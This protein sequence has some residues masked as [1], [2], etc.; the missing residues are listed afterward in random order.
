MHHEQPICMPVACTASQRRVGSSFF[1]P[2]WTAVSRLP[3]ATSTP[4]WCD[5]AAVGSTIWPKRCLV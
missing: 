1:Q 3:M 4:E 2:N 5:A